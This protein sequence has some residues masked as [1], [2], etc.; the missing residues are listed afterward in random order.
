[1][2]ELQPVDPDYRSRVEW[3]LTSAPFIRDLGVEIVRIAP[4]L[5]ET[6]L[7][8]QERHRQHHGFVHAGVQATLADHTAGSAAST[9][10]AADQLVLTAEFKIN[11]LRPASGEI[12]FCRAEVLKP[13]RQLSVVESEMWTDT[14]GEHR[15]VAKA[16]VTLAIMASS[17]GENRS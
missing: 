2:S 1:M 12:L 9:L 4:G 7:P 11:L 13:G 8:L 6:R 5:C 14:G 3:I 17:A 15:L 16:T 10:I